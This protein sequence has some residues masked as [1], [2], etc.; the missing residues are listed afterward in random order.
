MS[1]ITFCAKSPKSGNHAWPPQLKSAIIIIIIIIADI[2]KAPFLSRAHS[3]LQIYPT[4]T[5]HKRQTH[6]ITCNLLTKHTNTLL[7]NQNYICMLEKRWVL[8]ADRKEETD[9]EN[10]MSFGSVF[11]C[12]RSVRETAFTVWLSVDR[13]NAQY[14]DVCRRSELPRGC[15]NLE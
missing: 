4:S 13:W 2:Y 7:I 6:L 10:L 11:Q 3:A 12:W 5:I 14:T 1:Q 8:S 9:W 15:V